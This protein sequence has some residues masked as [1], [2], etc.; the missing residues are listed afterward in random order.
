MLAFYL[1]ILIL[2]LASSCLILW[3]LPL[4]PEKN[5]IEKPERKLSIIIPARNEAAN[6]P[7]LLKS[8]T[9]QKDKPYEVLVVDDESED[10]TAQV[11][12]EYGAQVITFLRDENHWLGK[13]AACWA[14]A[15][16]AQG[17]Y[18]LFLDADVF[19]S[20]ENSLSKI[21]HEFQELNEQGVL[22]IQP[23]HIIKRRYE[24]LSVIF[25]II[26]LVGMNCF[27][28]FQD[29]IKVAGAFG[30]SLL[31][32]RDTYFKVGGHARSRQA[33]MDHVELGKAFLDKDL[34][35]NLYGGKNS[36]NFR[37]Y[38]DGLPA[39]SEGWS[40]SFATASLSTHPIIII[41]ISLLIVGAFFSFCFPI[42]F[43]VLNN[44][45]ATIISLNGYFVFYG[46]FYRMARLAGNFHWQSLISYPILFIFFV[47][48][49]IWSLIKTFIL[50]QVTW[51]GRDISL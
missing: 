26:V 44:W 36:L 19:L 4:I 21:I 2:S 32:R 7:I 35:V 29:K 38:P 40:K 27:S 23:Y 17:D 12:T 47:G 42:Y 25:N 5:S 3:K 33:M 45:S 41:G 22:S 46:Y 31:V 50:K 51:K 43:F 15:Q 11:A 28:F 6:L 1:L 14:G 39:L 8:I 18:L 34:P 10:N 49:F 24:D 37:M 16:A 30:P 48:L 20:Q 9:T 13:S